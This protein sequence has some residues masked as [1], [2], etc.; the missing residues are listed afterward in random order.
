ME[1]I[2]VIV[3][4]KLPKCIVL[5]VTDF[6]VHEPGGLDGGGDGEDLALQAV[7]PRLHDVHV[8]DVRHGEI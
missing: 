7:Q 4:S 5:D 8:G 3:L 2:N 6:V 1:Y